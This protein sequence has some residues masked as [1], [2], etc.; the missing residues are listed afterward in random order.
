MVEPAADSRPHST[1]RRRTLAIGVPIVATIAMLFGLTSCAVPPSLTVQPVLTG[2]NIPWDLTFAPDGTML[3]TE[4]GGGIT[5]R[6]PDGTIR[7]LNADF[8]NLFAQGESGLM[9]IIV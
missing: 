8:T 9:G 7:K 5:I 6:R 1:L 4:R 2:L 3:V